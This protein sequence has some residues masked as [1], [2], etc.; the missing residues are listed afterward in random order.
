[1]LFK[2]LKVA[3]HLMI[4]NIRDSTILIKNIFLIK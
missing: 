2:I 4:T 1:M 3:Q